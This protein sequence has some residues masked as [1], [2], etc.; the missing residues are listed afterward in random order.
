MLQSGFADRLMK[1]HMQAAWLSSH[2]CCT[3]CDRALC[4]GTDH[5][6]NTIPP[7]TP[8]LNTYVQPWV[9]SKRCELN[10]E[11]TIFSTTATSPNH[12]I[13]PSRQNNL[14]CEIQSAYNTT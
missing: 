3:Y 1:Y 14:R 10:K 5:F 7:I 2:I 4:L 8:T 12:P 9:K 13:R 6:F 11:L